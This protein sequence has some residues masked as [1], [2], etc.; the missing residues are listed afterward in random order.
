MKFTPITMEAD[1]PPTKT[2]YSRFF[3]IVI[4]LLGGAAIALDATSAFADNAKTDRT[5]DRAP[6]IRHIDLI[7]FSHTDV[8][9][10]DHPDICRELQ[11]RYLDIAIDAVLATRDKPPAERFCWTAEATISVDDW[12]QSASPQRREDFLKAVDSGQLDISALA[13]N[14][15]PFLGGG[16]GKRWS[17]GC[18]KTFG[19]ECSRRWRCRTT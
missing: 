15:T 19:G 11:K 4:L 7:H 3:W 5:N 17:T 2:R 18:R 8:G 16:N 1:M 12:W 6:I 10:T 14:N 13:M 9:F